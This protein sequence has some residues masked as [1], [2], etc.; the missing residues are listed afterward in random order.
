[1]IRRATVDDLEAI[2]GMVLYFWRGLN[3]GS[4]DLCCD[5]DTVADFLLNVLAAPKGMIF[6]AVDETTGGVSGLIA[7]VVEPWLL[8]RNI[9]MLTELGWFVLPEYREEHPFA[10]ALLFRALIRW[11][12]SEGAAAATF[13]ST[14]RE[15]SE[16]VREFYGKIGFI[17][18]DNNYIGR[19]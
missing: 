16:M 1:M 10:A 5:P 11:A 15:E 4:L 6:A 17:N 7:G 13:S 12:K 8:N 14:A 2:T 19:I 3:H 18:T 9:L